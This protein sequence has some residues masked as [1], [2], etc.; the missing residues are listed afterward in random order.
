MAR[1]QCLLRQVASYWV[2]SAKN[3]NVHS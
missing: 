3:D 2:I 1:I